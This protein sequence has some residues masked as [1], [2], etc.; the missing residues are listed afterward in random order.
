ML[1]TGTAHLLTAACVWAS[2]DD[3]LDKGNDKV[4]LFIA[5]S[6]GTFALMAAVYCIYN[7]FYTKQQYLHTQLNNDSGKRVDFCNTVNGL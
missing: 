1:H 4:G 2:S 5:A 3:S 7:K 6:I